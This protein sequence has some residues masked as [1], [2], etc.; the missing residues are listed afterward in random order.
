MKAADRRN[1]ILAKLRNGGC[2]A[3][4]DFA[5]AFGCSRQTVIKD[6]EALSISY[7]V[8]TIRGRYGGG[9]KLADWYHPKE[10]YLSAKQLEVLTRLANSAAPEDRTV[11]NSIMDQFGPK[12]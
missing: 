12:R 9:V 2:M 6:I 4:Q 11:L 8:I 1:L 10:S 3:M 5:D 7:P